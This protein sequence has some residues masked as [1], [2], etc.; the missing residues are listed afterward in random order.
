MGT[1]IAQISRPTGMFTR[2][3]SIRPTAWKKAGKVCPSAMPAPMQRNTQT[4]SQ[5]SKN[6][7]SAPP[8]AFAVTSHWA[9]ISRA[10]LV[11]GRGPSK[12]WDGA[13]DADRTRDLV[14]TKDVL[15]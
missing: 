4:V 11:E 9:L 7:I 5:R 3:T 6:P 15:Y 10:H 1:I 12:A 2:A 14:L 13:H 8:A